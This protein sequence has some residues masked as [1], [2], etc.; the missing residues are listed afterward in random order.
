MN[1]C[2]CGYLGSNTHYCTCTPKQ[3]Q[4]YQNRISG[5]V[6]DRF[7][8]DLS[9]KS[10][11]FEDI[12]QS[13][14]ESSYEIRQRVNEARERQYQRYGK[15]LCNGRVSYENLTL[16][17]LLPDQIKQSL[18]SM[19]IKKKWSNRAQLKIIRL[20]LT[21]TDLK[22]EEHITEES[23]WEAITISRN[24]DHH[25]IGMKKRG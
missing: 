11:N 25:L 24:Q 20:A 22:G 9:L 23:L 15:D 19:T 4:S 7:D 16:Y 5:P 1:P 17:N 13:T 21:I 18:Y 10:A 14:S 12:N 2:P 6:H 8:I 3:I